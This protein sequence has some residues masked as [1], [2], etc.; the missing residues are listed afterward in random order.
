MLEL[1]NIHK[2]FQ[3]FAVKAISLKV[4]QG[5]Y[6]IILGKSGAGKTIVLETIAGLITPDKGSIMLNGNDIT[7]DRIQHRKI[8]IVF[9]DYAVFPHK[10]VYQNIAYPLKKKYNKAEIEKKVLTLAD[11]TGIKPILHRYPDTLS[12]GEVQRTVLSRTLAMEPEVLLLDE[13]LTSLDVQY[14]RE[15]QSLLR[16]LNEEGLTMIHVTHDYQEAL[17]LANR[18]A[19]I[20]KGEIIQKGTVQEVFHAPRNKFIADFVGIRN[21]FVAE[22]LSQRNAKNKIAKIANDLYFYISNDVEEGEKK[23]ITIEANNII[24][25]EKEL[26]STALNNFE[27]WIADISPVIN[28]LEV[29]VDIGVKMV[30]MIT[31]SSFKRLSLR[32]GTKVWISFKASAISV[33][34]Y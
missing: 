7:K 30:V 17:A 1:I 33:Q 13:P 12:G 10:T 24:I 15:L 19:V 20:N 28:G 22:I 26:E 18:I 8:G 9:Q 6:Y 4:K 31:E 3:D 21:F 34:N 32:K 5:D 11:K 29:I 27:G 16:N 25:S 2:T 23:V 14:K